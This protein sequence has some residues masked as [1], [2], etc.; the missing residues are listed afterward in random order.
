[1]NSAAIIAQSERHIA[2]GV[3][4]LNRK[5]PPAARFCPGGGQPDL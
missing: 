2:G 4:S 5:A 1:M 3:V